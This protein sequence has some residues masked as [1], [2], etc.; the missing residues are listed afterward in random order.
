MSD[1][2]R[3]FYKYISKTVSSNTGFKIDLRPKNIPLLNF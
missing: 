3:R 2:C 1:F